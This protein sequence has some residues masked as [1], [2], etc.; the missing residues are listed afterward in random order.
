MAIYELD[1]KKPKLPKKGSYW[2][3]SNAYVIGDVEVHEGASIWFN[4]VVRGDCEKIIIGK[5]STIAAGSLVLKNVE[6]NVTVAGI[7][8]KIINK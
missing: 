2:V 4:T 7:P 6:P 3:A 1:N 8:A 5:N